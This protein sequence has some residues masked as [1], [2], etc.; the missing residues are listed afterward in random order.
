[1]AHQK[2]LSRGKEKENS[3]IQVKKMEVKVG[4]RV[5]KNCT[6]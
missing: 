4:G 3:G 6:W 2:T 1:M 5:S